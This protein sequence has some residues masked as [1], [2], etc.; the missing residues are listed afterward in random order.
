MARPTGW[1]PGPSTSRCRPITPR[2]GALKGG[3][4]GL[5][6]GDSAPDS[7]GFRDG[8]GH[9]QLHFRPEHWVGPPERRLDSPRP[10]GAGSA[11]AFQVLTHVRSFPTPGRSAAVGQRPEPTLLKATTRVRP[12]ERK[13]SMPNSD[14]K[15]EH[16][17]PRC[18]GRAG[19]TWRDRLRRRRRSRPVGDID[20]VEM[21][22]M[23]PQKRAAHRQNTSSGEKGIGACG[24][25][26]AS[27]AR[28]TAGGRTDREFHWML[29]PGKLRLCGLR[30]GSI[31][32]DQAQCIS[33]RDR[34]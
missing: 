13:S 7:P 28:G 26:A 16:L 27:K 11:Q 1:R 25:P 30:F 32:T 3:W 15:V 29:T 21:A 34:V 8:D 20:K 5:V 17:R 22:T 14:N 18:G 12:V 24:E 4:L 10:R 2:G 6:A 23:T 33:W 9:R 31:F 19:E